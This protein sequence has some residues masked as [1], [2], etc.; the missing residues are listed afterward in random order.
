MLPSLLVFFNKSTFWNYFGL[1][2]EPLWTAAVEY[3][4]A[5]THPA[6]QTTQ[7]LVDVFDKLP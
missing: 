4:G 7:Q 5:N 3:F 1:Q 6:S 2:E